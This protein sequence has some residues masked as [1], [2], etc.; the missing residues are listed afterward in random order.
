MK[1][2]HIAIVVVVLA[3]GLV[4]WATRPDPVAVNLVAVERGAVELTVS[5]T[6]A[7]T[8]EACRRAR[9]SMPIGGQIDRL[10]VSEGDRV[11]EGQLLMALWN[12]DRAARLA[13]TRAALVSATRDSESLCIAAASDRREAR[14]LEGLAERRL[15]SQESAD[16]AHARAD[17]SSASCEAGKARQLQAEAAVQTAEA[18]LAQTELRAPFAGVVADVTGE[19]GE[20][21][22]PSPPGIPTPPAIDLVT[23]DCHYI[24]A[25]IDEV[26][27]SDIDLG[28][29]VRIT[30][31]AFRGREFPGTVTRIAPY[32]MDYERQA[33]T[34]TVEAQFDEVPGDIRLLAGYSADLE[35]ILDSHPDTLRLP[36]EVILEG[37]A[38]L[39]I[40]ERGVLE[41]RELG[42]GLA[43][44]RYT[45]ITGGLS[46]GDRVVAN[47]GAAGVVPGA[48]ARVDGAPDSP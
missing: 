41:R 25:P 32:V 3:A 28:M 5:N 12:L 38:V 21:V 27:A 11:E 24:S 46:R 14:R 36:S 39:L 40:N 2:W 10:P 37:R 48:R 8:V 31:D 1:V 33:R 18:H 23:D 45:E 26:D 34:V 35:I 9:L 16:L 6:R 17:A 30:L 43:N 44:W 20:Y 19:V 42:I 47:V 7:G 29:P 15:V 22:T 4:Y 13:E